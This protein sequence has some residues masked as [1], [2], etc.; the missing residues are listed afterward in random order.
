MRNKKKRLLVI[1][2]CAARTAGVAHNPPLDRQAS[3]H[4]CLTECQRVEQPVSTE[5][6]KRVKK[7]RSD[8]LILSKVRLAGRDEGSTTPGAHHV[9]YLAATP[10]AL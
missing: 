5:R 2:P 7:I 9:G 4:Q 8:E 6:A 10:L 1:E 3:W